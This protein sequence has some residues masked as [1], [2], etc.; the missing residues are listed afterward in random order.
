MD[1]KPSPLATVSRPKQARSERTLQRILVAAQE[2]IEEKG[3]ADASI[4][5]IVRRAGSSVGGFYGRFKDKNE[6]LLALE[7]RFFREMSERADALA[8]VARWRQA[9]LRTVAHG[10]VGELLQILREHRNLVAAFYHRA[11]G[12]AV[13][14]A[15]AVRFQTGVSERITALLLERQDPIDHPRPAVG[16]E[17]GVHFVFG[18]AL[19]LIVAGDLRVGGRTLSDDELR[20]ELV[21]NFL[22]Y[23]G[24]PA[25][26][27]SRSPA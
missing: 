7:E 16:I 3:L 19:Q 2:L 8:D 9:D 22:H 13:A 18:I 21:R 25:E 20:E 24:V 10:L 14:L 11:T 5:E 4:P 15:E 17:L 23:L 26:R 6:L 1:A 12:D 27:A